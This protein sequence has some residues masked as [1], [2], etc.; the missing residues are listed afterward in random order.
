MKNSKHKLIKQLQEETSI[1]IT[2]GVPN[3]YYEIT[4]KVIGLNNFSLSGSKEELLK[5][6]GFTEEE[7]ESKILEY[8][9]K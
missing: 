5:H 9:N 2:F 3:Y 6:F 1:A 4:N 8:L 7:L